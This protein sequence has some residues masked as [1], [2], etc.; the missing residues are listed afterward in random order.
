M[1]DMKKAKIIVGVSIAV[2]LVAIIVTVVVLA[3]KFSNRETKLFSQEYVWVENDDGVVTM[4]DGVFIAALSDGYVLVKEDKTISKK[5]SELRLADE[6]EQIYEFA[7]FDGKYGRLDKSGNEIYSVKSNGSFIGDTAKLTD[8]DFYIDRENNSEYAKLGDKRSKAFDKVYCHSDIFDIMDELGASGEF[9]NV[10]L[11]GVFF[12]KDGADFVI[13]SVGYDDVINVSQNQI[14]TL[15]RGFVTVLEA[16]GLTTYKLPSLE[17]VSALDSVAG[18]N[19]YE[20][21]GELFFYESG[22]I[23]HVGGGEFAVSF[24]PERIV[25]V[26]TENGLKALF[27]GYG[28][29][30]YFYNGVEYEGGFANPGGV[31]YQV[32]RKIISADDLMSVGIE[33]NDI[34]PI[35]A[36]GKKFFLV[37]ETVEGKRALYEYSSGGLALKSSAALTTYGKKEF[38]KENYKNEF[39][40]Y[41]IYDDFV[42]DTYFSVV[43][44]GKDIKVLRKN[45]LQK[46]GVYTDFGGTFEVKGATDFEDIYDFS[47][48]NIGEYVFEKEDGFY[49]AKDKIVDKD[50]L[51]ASL[52]RVF[53]A[54]NGAYVLVTD[55]GIWC[56]SGEISYSQFDDCVLIGN[57]NIALISATH[58]RI[59]KVT[60]RGFED[61]SSY[62][63]FGV[64]LDKVYAESCKEAVSGKPV[65]HG[66][67]SGVVFNIGNGKSGFVGADGRLALSPVYDGIVLTPDY[68]VVK[69]GER[70][71][72]SDLKGK[73]VT[74]FKYTDRICL[75]GFL[76]VQKST[77]EAELINA[78]GNKVAEDVVYDDILAVRNLVMRSGEY[79]ESASEGYVFVNIGGKYRLIK[80]Y[81]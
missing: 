59:V 50:K 10:L 68:V 76:M 15:K 62:G 45:L 44:S 52:K 40:T 16:E 51:G 12:A 36:D 70:Y 56:Q 29:G 43:A 11:S 31:L 14:Q 79:V 74:D 67:S 20:K 34:K 80:Y 38:A 19:I 8:F 27:E 32:G 3:L 37:G 21:D 48:K 23:K 6:D 49:A 72:L 73:L 64:K 55:S 77:G 25:D 46:D 7:T 63:F 75:G 78:R 42:Y 1:K 54:E 30:F 69:S 24:K 47:G 5:Y 81:N 4:H 28:T 58:V 53:R 22:K 61:V 9:T 18:D 57:S 60:K 41:F 65:K 17:K 13:A 39:V 71:A 33:T 35:D 2:V 66:M 26:K